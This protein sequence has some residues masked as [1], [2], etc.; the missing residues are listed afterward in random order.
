M[1]QII[2]HDFRKKNLVKVNQFSAI[3]SERYLMDGY[4]PRFA[5]NTSLSIAKVHRFPCHLNEFQYGQRPF[6]AAAKKTTKPN[7]NA[8]FLPL[9][10]EYILSHSI[11]V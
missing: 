8:R 2:F 4:Q 11:W 6:N 3:N 9:F 5:S 10:H 7:I 1:L